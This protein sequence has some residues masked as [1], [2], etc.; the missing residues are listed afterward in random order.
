MKTKLV[1]SV[2]GLSLV[3]TVQATQRPYYLYAVDPG[4][5]RVFAAGGPTAESKSSLVSLSPGGSLQSI[6]FKA[7]GEL[8][9]LALDRTL[10]RLA[11]IERLI[12]LPAKS[13]QPNFR[14]GRRDGFE[15]STLHVLNFDGTKVLS[16]PNV[17]KFAWR[18]DG[19]QLA[20]VLGSYQGHDRD[21]TIT[22]VQIVGLDGTRRTI[23]RAALYLTWAN[24]DDAIYIWDTATVGKPT[25]HRYDPVANRLEPTQYHSVYFSRSGAHYYKP[26]GVAGRPG[27]YRRS[28]NSDLTSSSRVFAN[29][30]AYSPESWAPDGEVIML[31]VR[32]RD[33]QVVR[34]LYDVAA[35]TA[36]EIERRDVLGW[37]RPKNELL[38]NQG[39]SPVL[40]DLGALK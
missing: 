11:V 31:E 28:T 19:T 3:A 29:I 8:I 35:D 38:M 21:P 14:E 7:E 17:R 40:K 36:I 25:V 34:L 23:A 9:A 20:V 27:L 24:F 32:K 12:E 2:I 30:V 5:G 16:V 1:L 37:G 39:G 4:S 26:E 22:E 15:K 10:S 33:R 13:A 6:V 18:P